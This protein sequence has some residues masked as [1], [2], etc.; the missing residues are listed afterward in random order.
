[1]KNNTSQLIN[2]AIVDLGIPPGFDV[3]ATTFEAIQQKGQIEKFEA[4]GNQVILY[5]RELSNVTPFQF[6]YSL[7]AKY[8]LRVQTPQSAVYEYYQPQNRAD[9]KSEILQALGN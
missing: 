1:V 5:L 8:P 9:S 3:D 2:M 4:A 7:R 6:N